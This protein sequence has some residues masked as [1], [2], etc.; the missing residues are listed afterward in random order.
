[1]SAPKKRRLLAFNPQAGEAARGNGF[2]TIE[3]REAEDQHSEHEE[4]DT[5]Q[6]ADADTQQAELERNLEAWRVKEV[7]GFWQPEA[8]AFRRVLTQL[9]AKEPRRL[10]T[11]AQLV[12]NADLCWQDV[13]SAFERVEKEG[14]DNGC[15]PSRLLDLFSLAVL[16]N[17]LPTKVKAEMGRLMRNK[18]SSDTNYQLVMNMLLKDIFSLL[19]VLSGH[20]IAASQL[21]FDHKTKLNVPDKYGKKAEDGKPHV[22]VRPDGQ[23]SVNVT[24]VGT[25]IPMLYEVKSYS[26]KNDD[27]FRLSADM[28]KLVVEGR[29]ACD[30]TWAMLNDFHAVHDPV[31]YESGLVVVYLVHINGSLVRIGRMESCLTAQVNEWVPSLSEFKGSLSCRF[32]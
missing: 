22:D 3:R 21:T 16:L 26:R 18:S 7:Q 32:A 10:G 2:D 6:Q 28:W 29:L 14:K 17:D 23:L 1:M 30:N 5:F 27:H 9:E 24:G 19:L 11:D 25:T 13:A 4:T 15:R 20:G 12:F 8:H 31:A